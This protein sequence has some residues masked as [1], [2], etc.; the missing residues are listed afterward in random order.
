M[1]RVLTP[2]NPRTYDQNPRGSATATVTMR[3]RNPFAGEVPVVL[4][5]GSAI[6]G[7]SGMQ[8]LSGLGTDSAGAT[9]TSEG[10]SAMTNLLSTIVGAA[11]QVGTT[12]ATARINQL[13]AP[14]S[15]PLPTS[16]SQQ[17]SQNSVQ[18]LP[19]GPQSTLVY[20]Q[21][22]SKLPWILGG[23]GVAGLALAFV[24]TRRKGKR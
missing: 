16:G 19:L 6:P 11:T 24:L 8:G 15:T 13:Y 2:V 4:H 12:L 17:I 1:H 18:T 3:G 23:L 9:P 20:P 5:P 7:M 22:P 10:N 21:Q 14:S